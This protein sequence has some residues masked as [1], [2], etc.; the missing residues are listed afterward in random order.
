MKKILLFSLL[1]GFSAFGMQGDGGGRG[2]KKNFGEEIR[3]LNEN[4]DRNETDIMIL[5]HA[6]A[7]HLDQMTHGLDRTEPIVQKLDAARAPRL[8]ALD[9]NMYAKVGFMFGYALFSKSIWGFF[10]VDSELIPALSVLL[11]GFY[12]D[13]LLGL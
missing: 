8:N 9:R 10:G 11:I 12:L 1:M 4:F 5:N 13:G 7:Q 3:Q 2:V 6:M